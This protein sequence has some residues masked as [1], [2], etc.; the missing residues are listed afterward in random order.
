M[1]KTFFRTINNSQKVC[2]TLMVEALGPGNVKMKNTTM[3]YVLYVPKLSA[4][5]FSVVAATKEMAYSSRSNVATYVVKMEPSQ[6]SDGLY[7][8]D[9]V[10]ASAA[11]L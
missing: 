2:E 11:S 4:N 7:Q 5:L 8:L 1:I 6:R 9:V 10:G 3:F